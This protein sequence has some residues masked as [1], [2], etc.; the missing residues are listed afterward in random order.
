METKK[1]MAEH[2]APTG[3]YASRVGNFT[4]INPIDVA[5]QTGLSIDEVL[6]FFDTEFGGFDKYVSACAD[7][8]ELGRQLA[9]LNGDA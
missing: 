1:E 9:R 7:R 6:E 5:D 4:P 8:E 2:S 3:C